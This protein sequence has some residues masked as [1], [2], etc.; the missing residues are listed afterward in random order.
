[1]RG[2][3]EI[4]LVST[5]ELGHAPHGIALP[6]AFLERAGFRPATLDLA[7]EPF[8]AARVRRARLVAFSVPMHTALRLAGAAAARVRAENPDAALAFHGLYAP[9]HA[10]L[11]VGWG[12]TAVLG[13]ECEDELVA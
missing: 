6:K 11:L 8:D 1:M 2:P 10:E 7:V 9:P 3:G 12:A 13:G 4:L 5:Y